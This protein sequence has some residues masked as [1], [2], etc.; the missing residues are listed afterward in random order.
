[1]FEENIISG[2]AKSDKRSFARLMAMAE[3]PCLEAENPL[4][5]RTEQEGGPCD[6]RDGRTRPPV[7]KKM[8]D[9]AVSRDYRQGQCARYKACATSP[10]KMTL[11]RSRTSVIQ[12]DFAGIVRI[13]NHLE[14]FL[15]HGGKK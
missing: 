3:R 6:R 11:C 8:A 15:D 13:L 14:V 4:N 5:P 12:E 7:F 10:V 1:M 2:A 9:R